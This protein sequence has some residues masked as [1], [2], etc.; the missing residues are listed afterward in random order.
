ME[1]MASK[2]QPLTV[3]LAS[4]VCACGPTEGGRPPAG[5]MV[6]AIDSVPSLEIGTVEGDP[7]YA[8]EDIVGA[9]HLPSGE[10]AVADR[11]ADRISIFT[12]EGTFAR[13]IGRGG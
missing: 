3:L 5:L 1:T 13:Q 8:F 4:L 7:R 12:T 2:I 10:M 6:L 11:G 9:V